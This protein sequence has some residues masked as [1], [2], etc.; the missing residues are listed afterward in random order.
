LNVYSPGGEI[1]TIVAE[2][3]TFPLF[4]LI[5]TTNDVGSDA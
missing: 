5:S 3:G 1:H 4:G 2:Y